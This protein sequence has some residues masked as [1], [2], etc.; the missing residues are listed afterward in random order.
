MKECGVPYTEWD[1]V[2]YT[3]QIGP[4]GIKRIGFIEMRTFLEKQYADVKKKI[5]EASQQKKG[6]VSFQS[7]YM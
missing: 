4:D 6:V 5:D 3:T 2:P 1:K 7:G